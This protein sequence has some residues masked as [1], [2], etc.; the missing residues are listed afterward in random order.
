VKFR[1]NK[2]RVAPKPDRTWRG[3]VY[4][5]KTE[6]EYAML[7]HSLLKAGEIKRLIEQ[8]TFTLGPSGIKYSPDFEVHDDEGRKWIDVKGH[9][10]AA[11]RLKVR[12]WKVHGPGLLLIVKR[13]GKGW[14]VVKQV[15]GGGGGA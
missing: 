5:S 14:K 1:R 7:L 2:Y 8:P 6:M 4:A 15:D 10:T 11:F 9:Q 3:K 13:S 12:L